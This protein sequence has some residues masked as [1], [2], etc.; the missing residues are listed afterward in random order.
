M[1]VFPAP[2]FAITLSVCGIL[3]ALIFV[4]YAL[5]CASS[6]FYMLFHRSPNINLP[7]YNVCE[8]VLFYYLVHTFPN[9]LHTFPNPLTLAAAHLLALI[10]RSFF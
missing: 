3:Y 7:F 5:Y 8:G 1:F 9:P 6:Y 2:V 4:L 10:I